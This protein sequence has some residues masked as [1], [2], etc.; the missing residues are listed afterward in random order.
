[1]NND[2][3]ENDTLCQKVKNFFNNIDCFLQCVFSDLET[4]QHT[5]IQQIEIEEI[6]TIQES[7]NIKKSTQIDYGIEIE[8]Y[9]ESEIDE[10]NHVFTVKKN[11]Q[12]YQVVGRES[13]K[14]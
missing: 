7:I 13:I 9:I 2:N 3:S 4:E 12:I 6:P 14:I 5:E 8:P 11:N 1:M 10:K